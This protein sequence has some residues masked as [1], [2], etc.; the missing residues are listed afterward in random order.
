[1]NENM[2]HIR[3]FFYLDLPKVASIYSQLTG[4]L[5]TGTEITSGSE[6][7]ERNIRK[8][9]L[10]IFKP[11]FGGAERTTSRMVES[12]VMHHDLFNQVE[13][14]LFENNYAID[15]NSSID[16]AD[17][18]SG[19]AHKEF[20]SIF[21]IRCKGWAIIEDYEKMKYVA[22][23]HNTIVGFIRKSALSNIKNTEEYIS[24]EQQIADAK[25]SA[26]KEKD[27]NKR[28]ILNSRIKDLEAQIKRQL[29]GAIG[30]DVEQWIIDGFEAWVDTFMKDAIYFHIYPYDTC[31]QFHI[32]A[33]LKRDCFIDGDIRI[34]D[35]AYTSRPNVKLTLFG[36]ITSI[37][38][39]G[40]HPF[41]PMKEFES[42]EPESKKEEAVGFEAAIRG[43]FRGFDGLERLSKF[44]RYPNLTVYPLAVFRDIHPKEE[45]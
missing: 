39:K 12:R 33:T 11:E 32:K 30:R 36:L 38:P 5:V 13:R 23:R 43:L 18:K 45:V 20:S 25:S 44:D 34:A 2:S 41:N 37:P 1:M 8:Y 7:D 31:E 28:A 10:K 22:K 15:I 40:E 21:Y 42:Q 35:F 3:D 17:I 6:K 4:G 16:S 19:K 29:E 24:L 14:L 9:D 26:S 27:R